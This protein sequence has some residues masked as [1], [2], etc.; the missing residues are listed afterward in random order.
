MEVRKLT[1]AI[2]VLGFACA[3]SGCAQKVEKEVDRKVASE[4]SIHTQ[5]DLN[6]ES[7]RA[8]ESAKGITEE[9][10][11]QLI[12]LRDETR[13]ATAEQNQESL[14]LR[15]VLVK[16]LLAQ[17]YDSDEITVIRNKIQKTD[18]KKTDLLMS[19]IRQSNAILGRTIHHR[20]DVFEQDYIRRGYNF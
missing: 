9:Q 1:V 8:L 5:D 10:R 4:T 13:R 11:A 12:A 17:N 20:D 16:E 3:M 19:A 15:A 2:A 7:T 6:A 18:Q 14:R